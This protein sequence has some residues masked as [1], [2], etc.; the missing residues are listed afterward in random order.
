VSDEFKCFVY[1]AAVVAAGNV[2]TYAIAQAF[3]LALNALLS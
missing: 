2:L 3:A 1:I